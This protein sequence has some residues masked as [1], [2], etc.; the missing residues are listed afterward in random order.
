M[1]E[2]LHVGSLLPAAPPV[3]EVDLICQISVVPTIVYIYEYEKITPGGRERWVE[4]RNKVMPL[5]LIL[6]LMGYWLVMALASS[7]S[8]ACTFG[9]RLSRN[10][11]PMTTATPFSTA[12][13]SHICRR[14]GCSY[15]GAAAFWFKPRRCIGL[16]HGGTSSYFYCLHSLPMLSPVATA[17]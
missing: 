15:T 5:P 8:N 11:Q 16:G 3:S 4:K 13:A 9:S 2:D 7:R 14:D 17:R 6:Y 12:V 10:G 1:E